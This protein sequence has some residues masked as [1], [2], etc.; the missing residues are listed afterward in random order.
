MSLIG[1]HP[2]MVITIQSI[3]QSYQLRSHTEPIVQLPRP[4]EFIFNTPSHHRV[5]HGSDPTYIDKNHGGVLII[6][7]RI[8]N[9]FQPEIFR[10]TYGLTR[11]INPYNPIRIAF[12]EWVSI[13]RN[14]RQA[15][16]VKE[17]FYYI[18]G[19]PGWKPS[20]AR[21]G[22]AAD[23]DQEFSSATPARS[24]ERRVGRHRRRRDAPSHAKET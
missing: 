2:L 24:E 1:F 11:N 16:S 15:R 4:I 8:F 21:S 5:H 12:H 22:S 17:A 14:I 19:P 10:P 13:Y 23:P 20:P 7:D 18:F 9:T 3:S 6:W